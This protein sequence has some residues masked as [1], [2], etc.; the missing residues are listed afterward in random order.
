LK[1]KERKKEKEKK[2]RNDPRPFFPGQARPVGCAVLGF[3]WLLCAIK[4]CWKG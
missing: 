1:N 3:F 4:S 2:G